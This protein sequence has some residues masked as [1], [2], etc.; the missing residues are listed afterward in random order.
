MKILFLYSE[1]VSYQLP[2]FRQLV[3]EYGAE[4]HVIRW[5][6][7]LLKPKTIIDIP[8][9]Y[10]HDRSSFNRKSL[11]QFALELNPDIVYISGWMD[12]GYLLAAFK[13]RRKSIPVVAGIDDKWFGTYKQRIGSILSKLIIKR[14]FISHFWV[15]GYMQYEYAKRMGYRDNEIIFEL[16]AVDF[17]DELN[18]G[19]SDRKNE[20]NFL[21]VG[22]FRKVKGFDILIE[23]YKIYKEKLNGSWG[24]ICVGIGELEGLAKDVANIEILLYASRD[25]LIEIA[26]RASVLILPSRNDMWGVVVQEFV[27]LGKPLILSENVGARTLFL[28]NNFNGRY[29]INN[30]P[31]KLADEMNYFSTLDSNQLEKMR[32]NSLKLMNRTTVET[33][34]ANFMSIIIK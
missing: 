26:K 34:C 18:N 24:L 2:I 25:E 5:D 1:I 33:S 3:K 7:N 17:G 32:I 11:L 29:F 20:N 8:G 16:L 10:S 19:T 30:S 21:Y 15:S 27:S 28:I 9:V 14:F 12:K 13:L 31:D 22:N 4:V 6:F 23:A